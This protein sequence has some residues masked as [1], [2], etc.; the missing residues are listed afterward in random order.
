MT[1]AQRVSRSEQYRSFHSHRDTDVEECEGHTSEY[2]DSR[3]NQEKSKSSRKLTK[4]V[5]EQHIVVTQRIQI[6]S[7]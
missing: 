2:Q 6:R 3:H 4:V 1:T 7:E 5:S